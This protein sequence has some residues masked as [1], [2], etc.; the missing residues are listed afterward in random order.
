MQPNVWTYL[1]STYDGAN[2]K[3]YVNG[4]LAAS[5]ALTLSTVTS[6]GFSIG[7]GYD[8]TSATFSGTIDEVTIYNKVLTQQEIQ[9]LMTATSY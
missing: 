5:Q 4:V 6:A 1:A 7:W 3:T 8:S 2:V 9:D